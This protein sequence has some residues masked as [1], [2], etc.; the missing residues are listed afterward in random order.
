[1]SSTVQDIDNDGKPDLVAVFDMQSVRLRPDATRATLSGW[2]KNSQL[3]VGE[4][5]VIVVPSLN[6]SEAGCR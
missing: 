5:A 3:F 6:S 4:D 1:L 2:L